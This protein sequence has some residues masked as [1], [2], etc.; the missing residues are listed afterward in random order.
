MHLLDFYV[1]FFSLFMW[2]A[3]D[4]DQCSHFVL[5]W[6]LIKQKMIMCVFLYFDQI[7]TQS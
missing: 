3:K 1:F 2:K 4:E 7:V 6:S 5:A